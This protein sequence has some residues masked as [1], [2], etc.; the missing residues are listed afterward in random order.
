MIS[1]NGFQQSS[2]VD[3]ICIFNKTCLNNEYTN[4]M[5]L[6]TRSQLEKG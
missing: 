1:L 2:I 3:Y 4:F 5:S 6:F